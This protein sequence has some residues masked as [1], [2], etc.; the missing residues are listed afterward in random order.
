MND[1]PNFDIGRHPKF[2]PKLGRNTLPPYRLTDAQRLRGVY[3]IGKIGTGKSTTL[4]NHALTDMRAGRG[5]I[6]IDPHGQDAE[7]LLALVPPHR[8]MNVIYFAPHEFP[9]GFNVFDKVPRRRHPFVSMSTVETLKGIYDL[10]FAAS[11]IEMFV[12][13]G[14]RALLENPGSSLMGLKFMLTS[15]AYRDRIVARVRDPLIRDFWRTDFGEHMTDQDKRTRTVSTMSKIYGLITDP[16]INN[17]LSQPSAFSFESILRNN[18]IFIASLPEGQLGTHLT[19]A[20]YSFLVSRLHVA[21]I[22]RQER[23]LFPVYLSEFQYCAPMILKPVFASWRKQ[24]AALTLEHHYLAEIDGKLR[25]AIFGT[26]GTTLAFT[27]GSLDAE[28]IA[29]LF[30]VNVK[31]DDLIK[32]EKYRAIAAV[33]GATEALHMPRLDGKPS[34]SMPRYIRDWCRLAYSRPREAIEAEIAAFVA[35]THD[36]RECRPDPE[37]DPDPVDYAA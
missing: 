3:L 26:V 8:L 6:F 37:P 35:A 23:H 15:P 13:M 14:A 17:C 9:T 27:L 19:K 30:S 33:E 11:N 32:L 22:E 20:L 36:A 7:T 28:H 18:K 24:G 2:N 31:A 25:D 12:N 29:K 16:A 21:V 5:C 1:E 4:L 10:D 34:R